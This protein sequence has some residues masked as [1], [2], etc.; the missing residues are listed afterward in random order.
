MQFQ[1]LVVAVKFRGL[2]A[3]P[4]TQRIAL[5]GLDLTREA[6]RF[7]PDAQYANSRNVQQL[8]SGDNH[9]DAPGDNSDSLTTIYVGYPTAIPKDPKDKPYP[10]DFKASIGNAGATVK[11]TFAEPLQLQGP[12]LTLSLQGSDLS[13]LFP[14]LGVALPETPPYRLTGHLI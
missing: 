5:G 8:L 9:G 2:L 13:K 4:M 12:D 7:N 14:L 11:G 1:C 10:I 6:V 3:T